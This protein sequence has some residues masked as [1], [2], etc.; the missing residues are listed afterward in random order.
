MLWKV[1]SLFPDVF[2]EVGSQTIAAKYR[3]W[4]GTR[5]SDLVL[6]E[7]EL[8]RGRAEGQS[9]ERGV[10]QRGAWCGEQEAVPL[11]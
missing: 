3:S 2:L 10:R 9:Q 5:G 4:G 7:R 6:E 11:S 8:G 1:Q